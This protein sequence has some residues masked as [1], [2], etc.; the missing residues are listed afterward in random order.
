MDIISLCFFGDWDSTGHSL[1]ISHGHLPHI[2]L[3]IYL[4]KEKYN[5]NYAISTTPHFNTSL[6]RDMNVHRIHT[7]HGRFFFSLLNPI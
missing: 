1:I 6:G 3:N 7:I 2:N 4:S 5:L